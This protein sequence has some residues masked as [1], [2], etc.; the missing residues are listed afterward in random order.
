MAEVK[1]PFKADATAIRLSWTGRID[2]RTR[3]DGQ[4]FHIEIADNGSGTT[5]GPSQPLKQ[6][7]RPLRNRHSAFLD[8]A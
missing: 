1:P 4:F 2:I 3:R 6:G 5:S 7:F 8:A